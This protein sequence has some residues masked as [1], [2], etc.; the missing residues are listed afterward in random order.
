[1]S[2]RLFC[3][4]ARNK[5]MLNGPLYSRSK[6]LIEKTRRLSIINVSPPNVT[7]W[8]SPDLV[9]FRP[10]QLIYTVI[11]SFK[12]CYLL[13][14][15]TSENVE[16]CLPS[17]GVCLSVCP[18]A[19]FVNSVKTNKRIFK[20]ISSQGSHAILLLL[21]QTLWQY[22][23]GTLTRASNAGGVVTNCNCR[24]TSGHRSS[25]DDWWSGNKCDGLSCS[26]THKHRRIN[27]PMFITI[28]VDDHDD[29]KRKEHNL[30]VQSGK[31]VAEVTNNSRLRSTYCT[32]A[33][34]W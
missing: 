6:A 27:E 19:T 4:D 34:Y 15:I 5:E 18:S 23:D 32:K 28:S 1:M 26:I 33:N 10:Q 29:E 21:Y 31:S 8:R 30:L 14:D 2:R 22:S 13:L 12:T 11:V 17:C 20:T 16:R 25:I 3:R 24:L 9:L 7:P